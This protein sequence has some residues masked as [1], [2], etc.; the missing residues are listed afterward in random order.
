MWIL[1]YTTNE[2]VYKTN[3][4]PD[5]EIRRVVA[6]GARGRERDGWGI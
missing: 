6:K 5:I 4:T 1:K 2:P 3:K